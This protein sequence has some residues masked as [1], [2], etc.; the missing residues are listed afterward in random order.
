MASWTSD[1]LRPCVST[2]AITHP[3]MVDAKQ[4]RDRPI[5]QKMCRIFEPF[6]FVWIEE[7]LDAYDF[8]GHSTGH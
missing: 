6:N 2:S 7:P 8:E 4:Q 1:R 5:A 3:V